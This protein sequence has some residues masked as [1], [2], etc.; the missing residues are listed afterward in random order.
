MPVIDSP[1]DVINEISEHIGKTCHDKGFR[2]DWEDASELE[3]LADILEGSDVGHAVVTIRMIDGVDTEFTPVD[4]LRRIAGVLRRNV[5]GTKLML[6]VS[7]ASEAMSDLRTSGEVTPEFHEEL[8]DI[9]IRTFDLADMTGARHGDTIIE[10][11]NKNESRKHL[12]GRV[13]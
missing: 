10:K 4:E 13:F 1:A 8:A 12:H 6:I 11:V 2:G 5:V 7:E 9:D 3:R